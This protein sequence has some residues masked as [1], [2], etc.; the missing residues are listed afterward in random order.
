MIST[1]GAPAASCDP[2]LAQLT[3]LD[4]SLS[5]LQ[6]GDVAEGAELALSDG[7]RRRIAAARTLVEAIVLKGLRAYGVNT[8]VGALCE[9]VIPE[10]KQQQLSRN[11]VMSHAVGVGPPLDA[12]A[13]RAI[14]AAA[15]NNFAHGCRPPDRWDTSLIWRTS[16]S[17][18]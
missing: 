13:V 12:T 17:F 2:L 11:I 18:Y 4:R 15:I 14:I 7:A 10:S 9:V 8:G 1:R 5:W 6:I 16:R 3:L